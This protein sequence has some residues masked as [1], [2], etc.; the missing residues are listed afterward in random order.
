MSGR[1]LL[2]A[3][4]AIK[5]VRGTHWRW[6]RTTAPSDHSRTN[7]KRKSC[8]R[9]AKIKEKSTQEPSKIDVG[10]VLDRFKR[11]TSF[12]GRSRTRSERLWGAFLAVLAAK[13]A[14]LAAMLAVL[15]A[16]LAAQGEPNGGRSRPQALFERVRELDRRRERSEADF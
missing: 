9:R 14:V 1:Q 15:D 7:M 11:S 6:V 3:S 4:W 16:K 5:A 12:R 13:L 8:Q 10:A 2:L